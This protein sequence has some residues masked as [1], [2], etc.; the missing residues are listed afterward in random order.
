MKIMRIHWLAAVAALAM[1]GG[2][3]SASNRPRRRR[4]RSARDRAG[5]V[6]HGLRR[7]ARSDRD[8]PAPSS[9]RA[10]STPLCPTRRSQKEH[11][12]QRQPAVQ[13]HARLRPRARQ[14]RSQLRGEA[15][16]VD[17][18]R[19]FQAGLATPV[20][21]HGAGTNVQIMLTAEATPAEALKEELAS[22]VAASAA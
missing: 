18:D 17:G 16:L 7:A 10:S 15:I 4:N 22:T 5:R 3:G 2:C 14:R 21:T 12:R 19:R 8:R 13:L 20:L 9:T 1:L 11:R 6:D